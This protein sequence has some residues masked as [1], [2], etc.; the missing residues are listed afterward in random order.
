MN[1]QYLVFITS[2]SNTASCT[3][4]PASTAFTDYQQLECKPATP[5]ASASS[6]QVKLQSASGKEDGTY[7]IRDLQV[8]SPAGPHS[9][10]AAPKSSGLG[11]G[12]PATPTIPPVVAPVQPLQP[13]QP[14]TPLASLPTATV[15][16]VAAAA[17]PGPVDFTVVLELA[18]GKGYP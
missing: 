1:E 9:A 13:T 5:V 4:T 14:A 7:G 18:P 12:D 10:Q 17:P 15:T 11:P 3:L 8:F 6:V 2:G 16:P